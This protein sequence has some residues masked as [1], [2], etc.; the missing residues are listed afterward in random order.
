MNI[1]EIFLMFTGGLLLIMLGDILELRNIKRQAQIKKNIN[2]RWL[3]SAWA[4]RQK[5]INW[6]DTYYFGKSRG[7][8]IVQRPKIKVTTYHTKKKERKFSKQEITDV[9]WGNRK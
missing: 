8:K 7:K 9:A 3:N 5:Y 4:E 1:A 2:G 6:D